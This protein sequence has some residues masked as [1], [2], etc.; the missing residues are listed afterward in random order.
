MAMA[1]V[2]ASVVAASAAAA[3]AAVVRILPV[4]LPAASGGEVAALPLWGTFGETPP[5]PSSRAV[6][7]HALAATTLLFYTSG[8]PVAPT[9]VAVGYRLR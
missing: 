9:A 1:V 8:L 4:V 3:V 5:G 7:V 6:P 2:A